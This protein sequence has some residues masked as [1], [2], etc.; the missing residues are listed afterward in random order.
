MNAEQVKT[1]RKAYGCFC[2]VGLG[3]ST[4]KH[5]SHDEVAY[6]KELI[7]QLIDINGAKPLI[8]KSQQQN[9]AQ[10]AQAYLRRPGGFALKN[11]QEITRAEYAR[12]ALKIAQ[13]NRAEACRLMSCGRQTLHNIREAALERG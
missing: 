2:A 10:I 13:G 7:A 8:L 5:T 12:A 9:L 3:Y 6:G 11:F 4:A 1:L